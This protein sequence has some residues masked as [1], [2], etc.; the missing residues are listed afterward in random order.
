VIVAVWATGLAWIACTPGRRPSTASTTA[1][2]LAQ[3]TP[4]TST[5]AV[6]VAAVPVVIGASW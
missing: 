4:D 3:C 2:S 6:S 5:T 1:F